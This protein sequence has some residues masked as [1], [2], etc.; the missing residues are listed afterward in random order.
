MMQLMDLMTAD[1]AAQDVLD[2]QE[3]RC[4][5]IAVACRKDADKGPDHAAAVLHEV[6]G[7][8]GYDEEFDDRPGNDEDRLQ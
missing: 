5:V 8:D 1:V 3:E 6:E 7:N 4:Q 2:F